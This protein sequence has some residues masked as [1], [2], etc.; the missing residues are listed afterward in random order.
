MLLLLLLQPRAFA[1]DEFHGYGVNLFTASDECCGSTSNDFN[2]GAQ[3]VPGECPTTSHVS[4]YNLSYCVAQATVI[5]NV[6]DDWQFFGNW[7]ESHDYSNQ[8]VDPADFADAD[9][10]SWGDDGLDVFGAD[11]ADVAYISSHGSQTCDSTNGWHSFQRMGDV[12][13]GQDCTPETYDDDAI[14][15][16]FVG[17]EDME[18]LVADSCN[19]VQNCVWDNDGYNDFNGTSLRMIAGYNGL[20]VDSYDQQNAAFNYFDATRLTGAGDHWLDHRYLSNWNGTDDQCPVVIVYA[21]DTTT[22]T[23]F[24]NNAGMGDRFS[25]GTVAVLQRHRLTGCVP[26]DGG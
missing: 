15:K 2:V 4:S 6:F 12:H 7:D 17:D 23:D 11:D 16:M 5:D 14:G 8:G 1:I 3:N 9:L 25:T 26:A 13:S 21:S 10:V 20:S 24:Y 22:A 19:S 18:I